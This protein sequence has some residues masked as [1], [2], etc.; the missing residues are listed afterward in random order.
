[1]NSATPILFTIPNFDTAGSGGALWNVV[2]RLDRRRFAPAICVLR[3]GGS[4]MSEIE[5]SDVPLLCAPF[6]VAPRPLATLAFRLRK[7]AREFRGR[8]FALWHSF[9]Y[10]DDYT[11]PLVARFAGTPSWIYTKKN[12]NWHRRSWYVRSFLATRIA[13][14]NTDMMRDFFAP[15]ALRR[16]ARLVPRGVDTA[17]FSPDQPSRLGLREARH[18]PSSATVVGCVAHLLPVKNQE[19]LIRAV[20]QVPGT[21]LWL[22]GKDFDEAYGATLRRLVAE[23]S[24][25]DRVVFFGNVRDVPSFLAEIDVFALPTRA[26]GRMEGCPVALLE[27]MASGRAS[28]A[29]D[30]PGSR[31]IVEAGH[32]GD[33]VPADDAG[34]LA[35]AIRRLANDPPTRRAR[36]E[37]ARRRVLESYSIEREVEAHES[38][39][40]EILDAHAKRSAA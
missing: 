2:S 3:P 15:A 32:S 40:A 11:E 37:A 29:S 4:L 34:A 16:R 1:M 7:A 25:S 14:Q 33:L 24:L 31:D 17:R 23:L 6:T 19:M 10:V 27:A 8:R 12:M 18:V 9:H 30:I 26:E 20:A 36:G 5:R 28:I 39:Y 21:V 22:A 35:E 13:A 38:L